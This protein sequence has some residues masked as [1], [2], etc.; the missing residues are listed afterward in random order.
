MGDLYSMAA[1]KHD[2]GQ[3]ITTDA[4]DINLDFP[5]IAH[6]QVAAASAVAASA[7]G[8]HAAIALAA[9][10]Q[11]VTTAITNPAVPRNISVKGNAAGVIGDV[12][13]TGT[14]YAG[15]AITE[16]IALNGATAV[17]GA[18]AFK[19]VTKIDL[20]VEVHAGTDTVSV[21]W[22]DKLGL[23]YKLSH[24]TVLAAYHDNAKEGTAPTVAVS[25][26]AIESNTIDLNTALN[27][28][29]V[30]AYLIV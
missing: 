29:I 6:F 12:V 18:K 24:N 3:T 2:Y 10:V 28:K 16:T 8:V 13:I 25:A 7:T 9:E 19:T 11:A 27:G 5:K 22:G 20:P 23:P 17:E 15:E 30:D 21:G 26:T 4:P 1:F 14:N